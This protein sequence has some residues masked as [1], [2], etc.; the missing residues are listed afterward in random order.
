MNH[1]AKIILLLAALSITSCKDEQGGEE[2]KETTTT[3]TTPQ[4]TPI[5]NVSIVN[6][7][8]H[9]VTAFTEG[10]EYVDGFI[11]EGTGNYGESDLRKTELKTGK[12]VLQHKMDA[13]YFGEGITVMNGKIYQLTY[14]VIV[15]DQKTMK[16][17]QTFPLFTNEGWGMTND[18]K[19][20]IFSDGSVNIYFVDPNTFKEVK[21]ISVSDNY[22]PVSNINE[23]ELINGF[24]YS[25]QW[26]T[27]YILKI[28]TASGK[29]V[30]QANLTNLR[31]QA[32][33]PPVNQRTDEGDPEYLNG[34]AYDKAGNRIFITGKYWPKLFEVKLD[35]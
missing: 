28:D 19:H 5:L 13:R 10:L 15:Y 27:D 29:V 12:V 7:Y 24:I 30:A 23:L 31:A 22:G 26:Q 11:Y 21:R 8:P 32:G 25:N 1:T 2:G 16:Q 3:E 34:I 18:G 33:I 4:P 17:L 9:D 35:N 14:K 20:I 6:Q